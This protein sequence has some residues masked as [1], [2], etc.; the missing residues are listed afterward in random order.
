MKKVILIMISLLSVPNLVSAQQQP[1]FSHYMYNTV[2]VNPAYAG[3]RGALYAVAVNRNQWVGVTD[4]PRT[5]TISAHTPLRNNKMGLGLSIMSDQAGYE[6]FTSFYVDY[7]YTIK[8]GEEH[9]LSL[10]MKAGFSQYKIDEELFGFPSV[11]EDPSFQEK[12]NKWSPNVG[13]GAYYHTNKWY[14]GLSSPRLVSND[15]NKNDDYVALE[16]NHYYAIGGYVFDISANTKLKPS[17]STKYTKGSPLS[18]EVSALFLLYE[19]FW[20]GGSYR[21]DD[22][23]GGIFDM[24][25]TPQFRVGYAY[26]YSFS[27]IRQYT[28]GSH[29]IILIYEFKF[30]TTKY[31]SPRYF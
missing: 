20:I 5:S 10:G 1:Q 6:N 25:I 17:F 11:Y 13:A 22:A 2:A 3:S 26:E 14:L 31:K 23:F 16:R 30:P 18:V 7:S 27:D 28:S 24:K 8:T 15:Y 29:E 4:A 9:F 21:H 12:L 19:K